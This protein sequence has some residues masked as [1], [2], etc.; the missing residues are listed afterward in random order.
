MPAELKLQTAEQIEVESQP[1]P[2]RPSG[3]RGEA[4][5]GGL[6]LVSRHGADVVLSV[7]SEPFIAREIGPFAYGLWIAAQR[8]FGYLRT[9]GAFGIDAYLLRKEE[10]ISAEQYHQAFTLLFLFGIAG[11]T[12]GVA[13]LPFISPLLG[14]P[15]LTAYA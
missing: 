8:L 13:C 2:A 11:A 3:L 15:S 10:E 5:R 14:M 6:Y 1:P 4:I 12:L 9:M 7:V